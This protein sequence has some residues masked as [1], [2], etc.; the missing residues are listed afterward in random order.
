MKVDEICLNDG[1]EDIALA[2][3]PYKLLN[4][5]KSATDAE[6]RKAYRKLAKELHPDVKPND[7]VAAERFKEISA[8]YTLLTDKELRA[9]FDSGQVDNSG[10]RTNPFGGAGGGYQR[11][12]RGTHPGEMEDLFASL[13]GM[14][15]GGRGGAFGGGFQRQ[16]PRPQ[17]GADV[18]YKVSIPFLESLKG[19]TKTLTGADGSRVNVKIP[20]GIKDGQSLRVRGKGRAGVNGGP[21]GDAKID[22]AVRPHKYFTRDGDDLRLTLPISLQEAVLGAKIIVPM[23]LGD[24]QVRI[25]TGTNSGAVLRVKGK[26]VSKGD[27]YLTIQIVLEDPKSSNLRSWAKENPPNPDFKPRAKLS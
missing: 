1:V 13:F 21:A 9:Q 22:V 17:K 16:A 15:M 11:A 18:R 12:S 10:Q 24:V 19:G 6:I 2:K 5:S 4:V 23:P 27:L 25:P 26:G 14:N 20:A 7:P 8:A 3:D